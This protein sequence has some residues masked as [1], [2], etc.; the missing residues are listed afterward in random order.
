M[1]KNFFSEEPTA[2]DEQIDAVLQAMANVDP[3]AEEYG[4]L[5]QRLNT[6]NE[7]KTKNSRKPVSSDTIALCVTNIFGILLIVAIEQR[8]VVN[9]LGYRE[10]IRP[11]GL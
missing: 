2:V 8:H 1:L 11:K 3:G 5:L 6:L 7:I 4:T 10:R 9:S